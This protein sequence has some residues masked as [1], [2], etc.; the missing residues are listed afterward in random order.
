M[1]LAKSKTEIV[2][3]SHPTPTQRRHLSDKAIRNYFIWPTLVL[4]LIVN[5]FPLFYSLYLSFTNY[6]AIANKAPVW[7]A[8]ENF[9]RVLND[10]RMWGYFS[11]TGTYVLI[12]VTLQC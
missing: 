7:V 2:A 8:L 5:V 1:S 12:S 10:P 6:S 11:T 3:T 9:S 4:L